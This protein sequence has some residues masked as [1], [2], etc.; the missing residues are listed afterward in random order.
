MQPF[1]LQAYKVDFWKALV[2]MCLELENQDHSY[3]FMVA[4]L[5][6]KLVDLCNKS[7]AKRADRSGMSFTQCRCIVDLMVEV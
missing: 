3:T 7:L 2:N 1:E 6:E 4:R 5:L